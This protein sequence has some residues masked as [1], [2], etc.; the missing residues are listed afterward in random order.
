MLRNYFNFIYGESWLDRVL[1]FVLAISIHAIFW[2]FAPVYF[3]PNYQIDTMEMM[4]IGQNWVIST[5]KHPAF[6]GWVVEI[7][8]ILFSRAEFVPYLVS[9]TACI[10]TAVVVWFFAS[11]FL[12]PQ[13]AVLA[14]LTLLS[15]PYFNSDS[16]IY[17]NRTFMR[18]FWVLAIY[19]LYFALENNRRRDWIFVGV[20]LALGMYCKFT[21]VVLILTILIFMFFDSRAR[22]HWRTFNPYITTGVCFLITIPLLIWLIQNYDAMSGYVFNSI[23]KSETKIWDHFISPI[24]FFVK[25]FQFILILLIPVYPIIGL[26]W[27]FDFTKIFYTQSGRYLT[28]FI[29]VPLI[30]QLL[31]ASF[32]AGDMR[33]ALGCHLWL[34][35]P[36][37]LLYAVKFTVEREKYGFAFK[38]VFI[39]IFVFAV[40]TIF[41][42]QF[43]PFIT[44]KGSRYHFAGKDLARVVDKI[45]FDNYSTPI[46]FVR[47]DDWLTES[48]C[49]YSR[50]CPNVYSEL[51]ATEKQFEQSG[52]VLL[53][54]IDDWG[55]VPKRSI[56]GCFG[57]RD[58]YYSEQTGKPDD[59]LKQFP[60][61]TKFQ[62]IE[63]E[64]KTLAKVPSIKIGIAIIPPK[65]EE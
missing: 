2:T 5:F 31:I 13:L 32:C 35:L 27:R 57:N 1:L 6:Q 17:N 59:W 48:V 42:Y 14:S 47:G 62:S 55:K 12:S 46:P 18:L 10:L 39:N 43:S 29:F 21:T 23:G 24:S 4:V 15:Y 61:A 63:L 8:S 64:Q 45:W 7:Y 49:V 22:K 56:R 65:K 16:T 50:N 30:L 3:V 58:F 60:N 28:F 11:K 34:L 20:A 38:L 19:F 9:Q 37:F 54:L 33:G 41:V 25:Q 40:G 44:G 53:W 36:T 26:R 51:W 52:G